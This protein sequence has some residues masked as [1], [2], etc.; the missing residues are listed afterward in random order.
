MI[1]MAKVFS[2]NCFQWFFDL[3]KN[4]QIY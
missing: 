3:S 4:Q 1:F 2:Q